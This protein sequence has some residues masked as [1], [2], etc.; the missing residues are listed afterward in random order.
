MVL[1]LLTERHANQ[2]AGVLS[3]YDP[4]WYLAGQLRKRKIGYRLWSRANMPTTSFF[5]SKPT[6]NPRQADHDAQSQL[7]ELH[8]IP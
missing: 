8:I 4:S 1:T 5:T 6:S 2:I 3:C 7:K